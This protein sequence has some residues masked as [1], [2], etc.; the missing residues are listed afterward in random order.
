M[1]QQHPPFVSASANELGIILNIIKAYIHCIT[2]KEWIPFKPTILAYQDRSSRLSCD[3]HSPRS[4]SSQPD[5]HVPPLQLVLWQRSIWGTRG[6]FISTI[7][8]I[9]C[10]HCQNHCLHVHHHKKPSASLSPSPIISS[11]LSMHNIH[12][13]ISHF[14]CKPEMLYRLYP[15]FLPS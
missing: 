11:S 5:H 1:T 6:S 13:S 4:H 12:G 8:I 15:S 14:K 3:C 9:L 2:M 10:P 7:E